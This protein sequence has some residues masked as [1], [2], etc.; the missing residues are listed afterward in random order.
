MKPRRKKSRLAAAG[1]PALTPER[2][3]VLAEQVA[4]V[5]EALATGPG[6]ETLQTLVTPRADDL[7]WDLH[8]LTELGKI[9]H[10]EIPPLLAA[11]FGQS[12]DKERR[13]A[14]KR[15][16]HLLKTK[17]V[18]VRDELFVRKNAAVSQEQPTSVLKAHLS[19]VFGTGERYVILEGPRQVLG[20]NFLLARLSDQNGMRECHL[21]SLTRRR[22]EELLEEFRRQGLDTWAEA[23]PLYVLHLVEKAL[24]LTPDAEPSRDDYLPLRESLWR[25]VGRP[26]DAPALE[27]LL[28]QM[29][30]GE[31]RA[32][33][34]Q[35]RRLAADELF[36]SWLPGPKEI[37]PWLHK[38]KEAQDSPLILSETQQRLRQE[39]VLEDATAALYPQETLAL[40]GRRLLE[41]AYFLDL[42]SRREEARAAQAAGED[43]LT[44][45]RSRLRGENPFLQELVRQALALALEFL[46]PHEPEP[47]ASPLVTPPTDFLLRR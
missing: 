33:L 3:A 14:L 17:G 46:K 28:P 24:A 42:L 37:E 41:M 10:A 40:W 29:D 7:A 6:L 27:E 16:L 11:L 34:E 32:Y 26:D 1:L 9:S 30:P 45:E 36:R 18:P 15:T 8:L 5:K 38:L 22:R 35:S 13:K 2:A 23:P 43:L 12:P 31:R 39:G 19:P 25:H 47:Q 21:F 44:G 4:R 20:G